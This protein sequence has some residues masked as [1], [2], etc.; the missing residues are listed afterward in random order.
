MPN[1]HVGPEKNLEKS[2]HITKKTQ[3]GKALLEC[4]WGQFLTLKSCPNNDH[5]SLTMGVQNMHQGFYCLE[6]IFFISCGLHTLVWYE[7]KLAK[8]T[9]EILGGKTKHPPKKISACVLFKNCPLVVS[10]MPIRGT[11]L[12]FWHNHPPNFRTEGDTWDRVF[13]LGC[14]EEDD[15]P[16]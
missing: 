6:R 2:I 14:H 16:P 4:F 5:R 12:I 7:T 11:P 8:S 9:T 13:W 1:I 3:K 10:G 15:A